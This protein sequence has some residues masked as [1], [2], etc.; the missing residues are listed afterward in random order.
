MHKIIWKDE[1]NIHPALD[2]QHKQIIDIANTL[3]QMKERGEDPEDLV[4]ILNDLSLYSE[5]HFTFEEDLLEE[6]GY[7]DLEDHI[8]Y[9]HKYLEELSEIVEKMMDGEEITSSDFLEFIE[10]WWVEHIVK[11]DMKFKTIL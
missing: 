4:P 5:E 8:H 6:L 10:D 11:E 1:Y 7:K 2:A 3:A 9:H